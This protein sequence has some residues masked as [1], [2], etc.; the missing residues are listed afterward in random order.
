[1]PGRPGWR[2]RASAGEWFGWITPDCMVPGLAA[3]AFYS[4][5]GVV[6]R[7]G[8]LGNER[9]AQQ[10][11]TG[12]VA[13]LDDYREHRDS[14]RETLPALDIINYNPEISSELWKLGTVD[15]ILLLF[16]QVEK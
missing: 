2:Y 11:A 12:I 3:C 8:R 9:A 14:V 6:V 7:D 16:T 4:H 15:I 5:Y 1:M 13:R 10:E